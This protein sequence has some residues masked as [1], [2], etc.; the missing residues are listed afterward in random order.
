MG[1]CVCF[2]LASRPSLELR[3]CLTPLLLGK[4][5]FVFFLHIIGWEP[6]KV[7]TGGKILC[8]CFTTFKPP[9]SVMLSS[10]SRVLALTYNCA[11]YW[12]R[13]LVSNAELNKLYHY[14]STTHCYQKSSSSLYYFFMSISLLTWGHVINSKIC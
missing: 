9:I 5:F 2:P 1:V 12:V 7:D 10:S 14:Y 8:Y 4:L 3:V 11:L 13:L 6:E